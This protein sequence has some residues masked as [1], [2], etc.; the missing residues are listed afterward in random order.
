ML[1]PVLL[2][3]FLVGTLSMINLEDTL[4]ER[5]DVDFEESRVRALEIAETGLLKAEMELRGGTDPDGDGLGTLQGDFGG[6]TYEVTMTLVDAS[7]KQY[8]AAAAGRYGHAVRRIRVG[9]KVRQQGLFMDALF[10]RESVKLTGGS[11]TDAYDSDLGTWASQVTGTDSTGLP[12]ALAEGH[13]GSNGEIVLSGPVRGNAIPGPFDV[14]D[15][16]EAAWGDT[17]PRTEERI[18]PDPPYADFEAAYLSNDNLGIDVSD[19]KIDYDPVNMWLTSGGGAPITLPGGTYLFNTLKMTG[20]GN[21]RVAGPS[22]IYITNHFEI[23]GGGIVNLTGIPA[24]CMV[25]A[26]PYDFPPG[27]KHDK[28]KLLTSGGSATSLVL[29]GPTFHLEMSGGGTLYGA[30]IG[31]TIVISGGSDFHYDKALGRLGNGNAPA[32]TERLYWIEE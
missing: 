23:S 32:L 29:Y 16:P 26:H 15:H 2:V 21:L 17:T 7:R 13:V 9:L 8:A 24:N 10:G 11:H 14:V 5:R 4:R 28:M 19:P 25:I 12:Y 20:G 22:T 3:V 1:V 31:N 30:M 18:I 27:S 6:G